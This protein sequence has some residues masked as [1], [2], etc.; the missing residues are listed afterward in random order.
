VVKSVNERTLDAIRE[1]TVKIATCCKTNN[2]SLLQDEFD[3]ANK[4]IELKKTILIK[5][6]IPKFYIKM[7]V[8]VEDHVNNVL[9]D[10]EG[11]KKMKEAM[12]RD[13]NRMKLAVKKNNVKYE[14][15]IKDCREHPENY[16]EVKE[17]AS[18]DEDDDDDDDE[19]DEDEDESDNDDES[20][21]ESDDESEDES[22]D[23][24]LKGRARWLKKVVTKP[25]VDKTPKV[26]SVPTQKPVR[27]DIR[28]EEQASAAAAQLKRSWTL[29][30]DE[31]I[32]EDVFN[33]RLTDIL[34]SRGKKGTDPRELI[35]KL[36]VLAKIAPRFG[37][38]KEIQLILHMITAMCDA[39][40]G[41]DD[42][43]ELRQWR[44]C[45][46]ALQRVTKLLESHKSIVLGLTPVEDVTDLGIGPTTRK[47]ISDGEEEVQVDDGKGLLRVV[48]TL[49]SFV[50]RLHDEYTK[51]LQ[52]INP[53]TQ[54]YDCPMYVCYAM[55]CHYYV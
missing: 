16:V 8:D 33:K 55:A 29:H 46:R 39:H 3:A 19:D 41:I 18:D 48:G 40:R 6:G 13:I 31:K 47:K 12:Q 4:M 21:D 22:D 25:T 17:K 10:K 24:Q 23:G 28:K 42:Y 45:A 34:A 36:E 35:L 11:L 43:L 20:E 26:K 38:R 50:L 52:Q 53:H 27:R 54:V 1:K 30:T 44:T 9:K 2:W 51:S 15:E 5:T 37:A 49:E 7:L 14:S 32:K